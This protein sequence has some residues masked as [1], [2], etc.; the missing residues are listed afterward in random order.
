[1]DENLFKNN[2]KTFL[3]SAELVYNTQDFTSATILYFKAL[4]TAIDIIILKNKGKIPKDHSERFRILELFEPVL[5]SLLDKI[6][7]IY[8]NTYTTTINKETCDKIKE[9]VKRIIKEQKILEDN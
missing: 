7:P 1:M 8:R 9:N 5:Y 2:I 6:Y 4:F 3:N